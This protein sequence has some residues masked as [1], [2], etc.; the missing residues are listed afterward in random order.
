M[1]RRPVLVA[2][3]AGLVVLA[4]LAVT[5]TSLLQARQ[6]RAEATELRAQVAELEQQVAELQ[7]GAGERTGPLDGLLDG[8]LGGGDGIEG[9]LDGLLGGDAGGLEDLLG[10]ASG[11]LAG[12]RCLTPGAGGDGG[13]PLGGGLG[14][15]LD[16]LRGGDRA[17]VPDDPDELVDLLAG[18]VE[19]LR[20]L[21]FVDDVAVEFLDDDALVAELDRVLTDSTDPVASAAESAALAALRAIPADA[22]L[23]GLQ[24]E[25]LDGQVAG[26][27]APDD[28]QLVVRTPEDRIRPLDRITLAHELGHALV[29]QTIG[30]PDLAD[31]ADADTALGR[32]AVIEGDATLL[33]NQWTLEHLSFTEQLGLLGAGDL[34]GQQ[35]QLARFPHHLQ[36]Q[37]IFPYTAGLDLVCDRWLEGGW[38]AVD[39]AYAEPPR[40]SAGVLFP[41]RAD[42]DP[43]EPP[44]LADPAGVAPTWRDTF[45]AA[46][47]LWLFEAPGGETAAA[48]DDPLERAAAWA[49]GEL[50][51]WE[52]DDDTV[53]GLSLAER[54]GADRSLCSSVTAW[55]T[56]AAPDAARTGSGG[57]VAFEDDGSHTAIRCDDDGVRLAVAPSADLAASVAR[58]SDRDR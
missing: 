29:D 13:G 37:L 42:E 6:A 24:R 1:T 18:Q 17:A 45:G 2:A 44:A 27:Y 5:V 46:P 34:A 33:M 56:A 15:L 9:L 55:F 22:D 48:L 30:L 35:E 25:L 28:G 47:L 54:D 40:T 41:D 4:M 23:E 10:G 19:Q 36:R 14:G 39:A 11:D 57:E 31:G 3:L 8:L 21:T 53:V 7:A 38:A 20:E 52:L 12:A 50:V 49:G 43:V 16:G 32:L 51:T 26:Y 58:W